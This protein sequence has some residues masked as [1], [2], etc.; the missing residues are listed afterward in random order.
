MSEGWP[1]EAHEHFINYYLPLY[2]EHRLA[3]PF[4]SDEETER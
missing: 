2:E 3:E 1:V 4:G